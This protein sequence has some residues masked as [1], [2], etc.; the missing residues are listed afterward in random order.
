MNALHYLKQACMDE[1]ID[2]IRLA[3]A[4]YGIKIPTPNVIYQKR[5][6]TAGTASYAKWEI[7]LNE[8]LLVNE[9]AAFTKRTPK[10]E[11]AHL[12]CHQVYPE[13]Y[14]RSPAR[15]G[16]RGKRD[17]HGSYW[18]EIMKVIG[19]KNPTRCHDY[20]TSHLPKKARAGYQY[21]C[22]CTTFTLGGKRHNRIQL[23][24]QA[25][26]I[27]PMWCRK[28]KGRLHLGTHTTPAPVF[29]SNTQN[30]EA[31]GIRRMQKIIKAAPP[32]PF[33]TPGPNSMFKS[34]LDIA[35]HIMKFSR[36]KTRAQLISEMVSEAGCTPAGAN[37]Y[38]AK[39]KAEL[40]I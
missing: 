31:A 38:Y 8:V 6:R 32:V 2:G 1:I 18:Q 11:L 27:S 17:I 9:G 26:Q 29:T 7:D 15:Y 34:K 13:A 12:I 14:D 22:G 16:R 4:H 3:E 10:H 21:T 25:G 5:G 19:I 36:T 28:C 39:L 35:R 40:G 30:D 20:D 24:L 33:I 37:T 23:A